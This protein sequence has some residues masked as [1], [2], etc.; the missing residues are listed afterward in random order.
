MVIPETPEYT[1]G[2][3]L[4]LQMLVQVVGRERTA[5][6]YGELYAKCGFQLEEVIPTPSPYSIVIGRPQA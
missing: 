4:D 2:K 5:A 6:E 1:F 3:W